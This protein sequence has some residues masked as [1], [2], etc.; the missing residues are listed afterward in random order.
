M[1]LRSAG[2][3]LVRGAAAEDG[4]ATPDTGGR[5]IGAALGELRGV[6]LPTPRV[7]NVHHLGSSIGLFTRFHSNR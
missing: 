1:H 4:E 2:V 7:E 5:E 6:P 3:G